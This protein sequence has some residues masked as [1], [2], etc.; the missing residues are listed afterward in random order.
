MTATLT[1]ARKMIAAIDKRIDAVRAELLRDCEPF[2]QMSARAWQRA[3]DSR[4]GLQGF[5]RSLYTRRGHW[6]VQG[7]DAETRAH[8]AAVRRERRKFKVMP[9]R[10]CDSCGSYYRGA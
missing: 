9:L 8:K 1:K 2:D 6:Q 3:W 10:Q 7:D 5:D 4:P